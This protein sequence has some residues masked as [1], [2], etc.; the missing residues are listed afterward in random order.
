M[1][2]LHRILAAHVRRRFKGVG[3]E[4]LDSLFQALDLEEQILLE[5]RSCLVQTGEWP[6]RAG[7][8]I[9][10]TFCSLEENK[11]PDGSSP[12]QKVFLQ[13]TGEMSEQAYLVDHQG[14][15]TLNTYSHI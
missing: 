6:R 7:S 15:Q 10:D 12:Q 3:L 14:C 11:G 1:P 13:Y 8:R 4:V 2:L 5:K 9:P